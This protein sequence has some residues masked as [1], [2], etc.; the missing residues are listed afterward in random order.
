MS[1]LRPATSHVHFF[2]HQTGRPR[3]HFDEAGAGGGDAAA[4]A[5]AAAA[6][7]TKAWHDGIE[8]E[9]LGFWQN[10]GYD[11]TSP[12][13]VAAELTKQYRAAEKFLGVPADQVVKMP[14][15]DAPPEDLRAFY[16]R[17]GAPKEAKEYDLS[18]IKDASIADTLRATAHAA[19]ISK[20]A[21]AKLAADLGKAIESKSTTD[22]TVN[23]AKLAEE[24]AALAKNWGPKHDYNMLQAME[25]ARRVGITPEAVKAMEN[26]I[27]YAAVMEHFR[28]IGTSTSEDTFIERG[29]GGSGEVTTR[30]GAMSRK[31]DLM[32][33][34]AWANRL[35]AGDVEA[36]REYD[37]L[38]AMI[39]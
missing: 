15:A 37:R 18:A 34:K 9:T 39:G 19:G 7:G 16:E 12:L 8:P 33:D 28:K 14:K 17:L 38:N 13:K 4:A 29:V 30:E 32:N 22:A 20:D 23:G 3:F 11:V 2:N 26:Q 5:A 35:L 27:G 10:K 24:K 25:G 6:A 21:A 1:D 36:R 31:S